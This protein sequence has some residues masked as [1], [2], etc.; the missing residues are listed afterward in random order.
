MKNDDLTEC[1]FRNN[2]L[3]VRWA[4]M[5]VYQ[6]LLVLLLLHRITQKLNY[7]KENMLWV[8]DNKAAKRRVQ[9]EPVAHCYSLSES[10]IPSSTCTNIPLAFF[11]RFAFSQ[12]MSGVFSRRMN[13]WARES[14]L[15][16]RDVD[17][18]DFLVFI[19]ILSA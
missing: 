13:E 1:F 11:V 10:G 7:D 8:I 16:V 4:V 5:I 12:W 9:E 18:D 3:L 2:N 17:D 19:Q 14:I 6:V 15:W